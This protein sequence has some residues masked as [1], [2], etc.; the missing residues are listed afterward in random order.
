MNAVVFSV[1]C[2]SK[3][4]EPG[5]KMQWAKP[6]PNGKM[7]DAG[8]KKRHGSW[9]DWSCCI[10]VKTIDRYILKHRYLCQ[11]RV[12]FSTVGFHVGEFDSVDGFYV[13]MGNFWRERIRN[14]C[15]CFSISAYLLT[16]DSC[17]DFIGITYN[18]TYMKQ[19]LSVHETMRSLPVG[20]KMRSIG[21]ER[22]TSGG[23]SL[24]VFFSKERRHHGAH[25]L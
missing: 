25:T 15:R 24:W 12:D 5:R 20:F 16:S 23:N 1:Y 9:S 4:A 7:G 11:D 6:L 19:C 10:S 18:C 21:F 13:T 2:R 14:R 22:W 3:D 17:R 8:D